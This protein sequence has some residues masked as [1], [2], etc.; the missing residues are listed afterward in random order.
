MTLPEVACGQCSIKVDG[1]EMAHK[2]RSIRLEAGV[3]QLTTVVLELI[4]SAVE[5]EA[6]AHIKPASGAGMRALVRE[7]ISWVLP[8]VLPT[9]EPLGVAAYCNHQARRLGA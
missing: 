3:D 1:Q 5:I 4:P 2:T 6:E 8:A 9:L 7:V